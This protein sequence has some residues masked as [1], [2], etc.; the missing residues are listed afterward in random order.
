M[1]PHAKPKTLKISLQLIL[2]TAGTARGSS[3]G[4]E[5]SFFTDPELNP[6]AVTFSIT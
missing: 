1:I 4:Q 2:K 5:Y 6:T 3:T